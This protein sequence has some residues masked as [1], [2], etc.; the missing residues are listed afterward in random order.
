MP[1]YVKLPGATGSRQSNMAAAKPK[2]VI[3]H[4][5]DWIESKFQ[6]LHQHIRGLGTHRNEIPFFVIHKYLQ[7][8][9][10]LFCYMNI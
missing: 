2:V 1:L 6:R 9:I 3:S 7:K 5:V 10:I 4:H 8:I